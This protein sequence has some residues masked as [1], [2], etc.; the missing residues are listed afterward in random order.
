MAQNYRIY[1]NE[2]VLIIS[3]SAIQEAGVRL[4]SEQQFNF[5]KAYFEILQAAEVT[6]NVVTSEPKAFIKKMQKTATLITAAGGL[7]KNKKK[8][9]LFIYRNDRWDLPKGKLEKLERPRAGAVRE[10]EEE[11]GIEIYKS[12]KKIC[13]TYH[14]YTMKGQVV[15]KKTHWYKMTYKG[16]G[17]LKPQLEEGI[18]EVRFFEKGNMQEILANTFP[19]IEE[20]M[21]KTGLIKGSQAQPSV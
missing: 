21:E 13:K 9:C 8:E 5:T 16:G 2:K 1:I 14:A 19:L 17:K 15:L 7:V 20:V 10:V 11:C 12:G 4:L 6:F 3:Q 18:T